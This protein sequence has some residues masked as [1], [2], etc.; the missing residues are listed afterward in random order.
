MSTYQIITFLG[1]ALHEIWSYSLITFSG[2]SIR[3]SNIFLALILAWAGI[4]FYKRFTA[5]LKDYLATKIKN[6]KDAANA[7]EKLISYGA[8]CLYVITILDIANVP[9]STFAF[10]GG[11]LAIGIGFGVQNIVNNFVSSLVI[12]VERPL[13]IGDII[14]SDGVIGKV[15]SVG[16]RCVSITTFSN[17]DVLIPNSKLMQNTLV[18]WTLNDNSIKCQLEIIVNTDN[19]TKLQPLTF[20]EKLTA[21]LKEAGTNIKLTDPKIYL[22]KVDKNMLKFILSFSC[23]LEQLENL[24]QIK[25]A[26]NLIL[27]EALK[28]YDFTTEYLKLVELKFLD[29]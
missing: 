13:K 6:D 10:V 23:S 25:N 7:L 27:L 29:K 12:M 5:L 26:L 17:V 20:S 1:R 3:V 19:S 11:A 16:A 15:T 21:R 28:K 14:E 8:L 18:N 22:V 9:L 4:R 2:N 24:E